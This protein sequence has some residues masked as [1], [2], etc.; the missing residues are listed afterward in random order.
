MRIE[1]LKAWHLEEI[2]MQDAQEYVSK[3]ITPEVRHQLERQ[4]AFA[5]VEGDEVLA[6][7]GIIEMWEGRA[8][9]WAML[10]GNLGNRFLRVHRA[11]KKF[12]DTVSYRRIEAHV[13]VGFN[14]GTRWIELLGFRQEI[15]CMKGFLPNGGDAAMYVRG[16]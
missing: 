11:V 2:K 8:L 6:C 9:V 13:D 15:P 12:L 14:N 16:V 10:S 1:P 3:W 5:A 4:M 7:S